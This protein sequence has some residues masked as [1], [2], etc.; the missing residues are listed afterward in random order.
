MAKQLMFDDA[1][2]RAML[3]GLTTLADAV[4]ITMGP[5][6][7]NVVLQK[8]FGSPRV[9]K[10]GVSVSKEIELPEPFKNMGAKMV[11]QVASK[12]SDVAGDGTTTATVLAEAIFREGL[13]YIA[14]GVN[15]MALQRGINKAVDVVVES[16]VK[17]SK[18]VKDSSDV[19]KVG[20][21]SANNN[22]DIGKL[23]ARAM[24]K[25]GAQGVITV[26]EGKGIET[27]LEVVEGMQFDK[28]YLSPYFMTKADTLEAILGDCLIL[29]HE[30]KISSLR[31]LVPLLEK[32][33]GS[34]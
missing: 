22:P 29:I 33:A 12:T 26:E 18:R 4:K 28:G 27:E 7:R 21:I 3:E 30:K 32:I 1:A 8:S 34:G 9:T 24:D 23:L 25:V 16:I 17:Q 2:R 10:D 6:G 11:N 15:P 19:A 31:D 14:A 13:K 20:S 5:T